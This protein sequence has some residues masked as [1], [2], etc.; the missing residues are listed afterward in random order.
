MTPP[1]MWARQGRW[2]DEEGGREEGDDWKNK[3]K[4]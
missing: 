4:K 1:Q 2:V 3:M